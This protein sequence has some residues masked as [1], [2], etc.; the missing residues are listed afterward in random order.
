[1]K[2]LEFVYQ[3]QVQYLDHQSL[4]LLLLLLLQRDRLKSFR[5]LYLLD[6]VFRRLEEAFEGRKRE[7]LEVEGN[8]VVCS[9]RDEQRLSE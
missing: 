6:R 8:E 5:N 3:V 1:M 2:I 7:L 9:E 4:L